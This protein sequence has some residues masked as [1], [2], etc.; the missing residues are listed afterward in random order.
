MRRVLILRSILGMSSLVCEWVRVCRVL[1]WRWV[2]G[3]SPLVCEWLKVRPGLTVVDVRISSIGHGVYEC[4]ATSIG[5]GFMYVL[6]R[7]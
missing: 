7:M 1:T 2:L 5:G 3:M 4:I 6:I